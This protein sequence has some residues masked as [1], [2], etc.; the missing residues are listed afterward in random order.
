MATYDHRFLLLW[1]HLYLGFCWKLCG[2]GNYDQNL[3]YTCATRLIISFPS[4]FLQWVAGVFGSFLAFMQL[5]ASTNQM[6]SSIFEIS[7]A[8]IVSFISR[9]LS[10]TGYFCY[11]SLSSAGVVLILPGYVIRMCPSSLSLS[12]IETL[13][14][15]PSHSMR[16]VGTCLK[17]SHCWFCQN[18]LRCHLLPFPGKLSLCSAIT[19]LVEIGSNRPLFTRW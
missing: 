12:W 2:W 8:T 19:H 9:G 16:F 5:K 17:E 18:G 6:Y 11:Q 4:F 15:E 7:V 3:S 14:A 1:N 10:T 13:F